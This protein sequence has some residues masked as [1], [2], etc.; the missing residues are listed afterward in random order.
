MRLFIS[1]TNEERVKKTK[2][3]S[4]EVEMQDDAISLMRRVEL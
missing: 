2:D 1:K 3:L 4:D